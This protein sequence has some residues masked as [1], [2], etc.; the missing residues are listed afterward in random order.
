[1]ASPMKK[2]HRAIAGSW[3][4]EAR[5]RAATLKFAPYRGA[6]HGFDDHGSKRQSNEANAVATD[7]AV[8]R[9]LQFFADQLHAPA[10]PGGDRVVVG[11]RH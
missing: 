6:S 5:P 7:D 9:S 11:E 8:Q 2:Y 4:K 10:D 1:M 3:S